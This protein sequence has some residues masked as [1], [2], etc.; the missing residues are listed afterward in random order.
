MKWVTTVP[1]MIFHIAG[2]FVV[3]ISVC[4]VSLLLSVVQSHAVF[5]P[6]GE[7][8]RDLKLFLSKNLWGII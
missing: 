7:K 6:F 1:L 2:F 3:R 8:E 4:V 5:L